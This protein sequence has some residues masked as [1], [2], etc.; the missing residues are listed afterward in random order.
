MDQHAQ[1]QQWFM[2]AQ[3]RAQAQH[4]IMHAQPQAQA[5]LH[6]TFS[7]PKAVFYAPS[8]VFSTVFS[9]PKAVFSAPSAVFSAVFSAPKAVASEFHGV[10]Q[11]T[12]AGAP[13]HPNMVDCSLSDST[14]I[15][16]TNSPLLV[17][18]Y[19]IIRNAAHVIKE[20]IGD[21]LLE[22]HRPID[23]FRR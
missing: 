5:Q 14:S 8:A 19:Q 2:Q 6:W 11:L 4:W 21:I 20:Q 18:T 16:K 10:A 12:R 23:A 15:C 22:I 13:S 9:A 3:A 1:A 17:H 7:A